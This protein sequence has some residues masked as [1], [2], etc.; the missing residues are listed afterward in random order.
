MVKAFNVSIIA[1]VIAATGILGTL[2]LGGCQSSSGQPLRTCGIGDDQR[3]H[4]FGFFQATDGNLLSIKKLCKSI[5]F[6]KRRNFL[7]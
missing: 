2:Q 7:D 1:V 5:L 6:A 4:F 3:K